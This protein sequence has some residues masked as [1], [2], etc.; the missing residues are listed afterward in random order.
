MDGLQQGDVSSQLLFNLAVEYTGTQGWLEVNGT[1][2]FLV[3]ADD[4]YILDGT[5]HTINKNTTFN[6]CQ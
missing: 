5:V 3:Y 4:N 2:Q 1:H 6:C